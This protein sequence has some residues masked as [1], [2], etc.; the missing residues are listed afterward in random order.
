MRF[1]QLVRAAG[2]ILAAFFFSGCASLKGKIEQPMA[3]QS[4]KWT[5][6]SITYTL[7][8]GSVTVTKIPWD[9]SVKVEGGQISTTTS[10]FRLQALLGADCYRGPAGLV[11]SPWAGVRFLN[12]YNLGFDFGFDKSNF[13]MGIDWLIHAVAV[14]PSVMVPYLSTKASGIGVKGGVIF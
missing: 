1:G 9:A 7:P 2:V 5:A 4:V 14:G 13:S 6:G 3:F 10:Q 11:G 12:V 8:N